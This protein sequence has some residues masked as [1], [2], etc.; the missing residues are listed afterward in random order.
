MIAG[1]DELTALQ[2][3]FK[4][5]LL[6]VEPGYRAQHGYIRNWGADDGFIGDGRIAASFVER[7]W[8]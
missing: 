8:S 7:H 3:R 2:R 1:E 6:E 5:T 4:D